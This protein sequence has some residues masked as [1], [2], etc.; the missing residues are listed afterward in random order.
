MQAGL[1]KEAP[2]LKFKGDRWNNKGIYS[3]ENN[4]NGYT[5]GRTPWPVQEYI[6]NIFNGRYGNHIKLMW[7][8]LNTEEDFKITQKWVLDKTGMDKAKYYKTRK[9]LE[10]MSLIIYDEYQNVIA[11]NYDFIWQQISLP[12]EKREDLLARVKSS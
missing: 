8:L 3:K 9:E 12:K 5:Y 4:P 10:I 7:T 1:G 2:A 11:I 6:M